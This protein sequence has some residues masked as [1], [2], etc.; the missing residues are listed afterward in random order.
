MYY[1]NKYCCFTFYILHKQVNVPM[2]SVLW[3]ARR[4]AKLCQQRGW[5]LTTTKRHSIARVRSADLELLLVCCRP[6]AINAPTA[7]TTYTSGRQHRVKHLLDMNWDASNQT[8][9][10]VCFERLLSFCNALTKFFDPTSQ[11]QSRHQN[12]QWAKWVIH[13]NWKGRSGSMD[14]HRHNIRI[15]RWS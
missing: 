15:E 5:R 2:R 9:V 7:C 13:T 8:H 11:L 4:R 12:K 10:L 14:T 3:A 1:A 6:H